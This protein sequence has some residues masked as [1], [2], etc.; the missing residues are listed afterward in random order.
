MEAKISPAL[1]E[2]GKFSIYLNIFSFSRVYL[3]SEEEIVNGMIL[4][5]NSTLFKVEIL[6]F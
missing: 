2:H 5:T 1:M 6:K 4:K 3:G